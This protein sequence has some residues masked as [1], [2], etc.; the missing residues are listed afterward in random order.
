[1]T[2][3][4]RTRR[5]VAIVL[6]PSFLAAAVETMFFF[7]VFDPVDIGE[8]TALAEVVANHNAGYALGFFFFWAFTTLAG[9]LSLYLIRTEAE[10][11]RSGG[12]SKP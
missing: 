8:G 11:R 5:D 3:W 10:V 6:W 12:A 1:M 7:A 2:A 9:A 4:S